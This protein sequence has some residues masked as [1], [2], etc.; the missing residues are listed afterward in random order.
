M[1]RIFGYTNSEKES[2]IN[3]EALLEFIKLADTGC[4]PCG[5]SPGHV[6]GWGTSFWSHKDQIYYRSIDKV[7]EASVSSVLKLNSFFTHGLI[8]LRKASVGKVVIQNSHPFMHSGISFCHNG[9]IHAFPNTKFTADRLL[10]EGHTDSETFFL[11]VLDRLGNR[12]NDVSLESLKDVLHEEVKEIQ[13]TSEW[14]SLTV[15]MATREGLVLNY[16]WNEKHP[17]SKKLEFEKYYTFFVG[18]NGTETILCSEELP[19]NGFIWEKLGNDSLMSFP[20]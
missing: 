2:Q 10:R 6:D 12:I 16:V 8:H 15:L 4:V 7:D 18:R 11:R 1:C 3:R 13:K 17:E 5:V 19:I 9:S 14:T 20:I